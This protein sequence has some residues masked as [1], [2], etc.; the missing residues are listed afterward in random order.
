MLTIGE[1]MK[2]ARKA[3]GLTL[4]QPQIKSGIERASI[5]KMELGKKFPTLLTAISLADALGIS[6][7]EYVGYTPRKG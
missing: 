3:A 4:T 7:D 5:N 6:I 1:H 2:A